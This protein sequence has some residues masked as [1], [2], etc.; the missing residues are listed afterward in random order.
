MALTG[1]SPAPLLIDAMRYVTVVLLCLTAHAFLLAA[2]FT[3]VLADLLAHVASNPIHLLRHIPGNG[4]PRVP[5]PP[6]PLD[7]Q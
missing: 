5:P 3:A 4:Y 1:A 2:V 7:E 6:H